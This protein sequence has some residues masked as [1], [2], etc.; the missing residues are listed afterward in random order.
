M[1]AIYKR[2]S[3]CLKKQNLSIHLYENT[4]KIWPDYMHRNGRLL[5]LVPNVELNSIRQF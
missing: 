4:Q 2:I 5:E 3:L 1:I